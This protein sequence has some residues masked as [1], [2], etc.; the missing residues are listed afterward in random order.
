MDGQPSTKHLRTE[1]G[2]VTT[3]ETQA[4]HELDL[5]TGPF[6]LLN[7][8]VNSHH[9]VLVVCRDGRRLFA[10]VRAFD[11]HFNM[12]L[13]DVLEMVASR[14]NPEEFDTRK[15]PSLFLRGD[16]VVYVTKSS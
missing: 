10:K 8:A 5:A 12:L 2:K 14:A 13:M 7:T 16:T 6:S 3:A 4:S 15:F 1:G 9:E 11:K